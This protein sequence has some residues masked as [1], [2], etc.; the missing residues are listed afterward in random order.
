MTRKATLKN[1]T[2]PGYFDNDFP[3]ILDGSK[4]TTIGA[5][6]KS[7]M[8]TTDNTMHYYILFPGFNTAGGE[9]N[10]DFM[11]LTDLYLPM[12]STAASIEIQPMKQY[13]PNISEW[14]V[15]EQSITFK[16]VSENPTNG[17]WEAV[18]VPTRRYTATGQRFF[19]T[20]A[21]LSIPNERSLFDYNWNQDPTYCT[22]TL[23]D[24]YEHVFQSNLEHTYW[25]WVESPCIEPCPPDENQAPGEDSAVDPEGNEND[26]PEN[27]DEDEPM[28][29]DG[30]LP[31]IPPLFFLPPSRRTPRDDPPEEYEKNKDKI[32][33]LDPTETETEFDEDTG[34]IT[35]VTNNPLPPGIPIPIQ[36]PNDNPQL[37]PATKA[38]TLLELVNNYR[39]AQDPPLPSLYTPYDSNTKERPPAQV[40]Y[41][42]AKEQAVH[43][44]SI[45]QS[46]HETTKFP[47]DYSHYD[48]AHYT[49]WKNKRLGENAGQGLTPADVI[50]QWKNSPDH[51]INMLGDFTHAAVSWQGD[52][53]VLMLGNDNRTTGPSR[54]DNPAV[55]I[56]YH[57]GDLYADE[58]PD[59]IETEPVNE[60]NYVD[61]ISNNARP[62]QEASRINPTKNE[63]EAPLS[64]LGYP[65][66]SNIES[67]TNPY[68][69][70][71][72]TRPQPQTSPS[73]ANGWA[74]VNWDDPNIGKSP[75]YDGH[76]PENWLQDIDT[77]LDQYSPP[78][79]QTLPWYPPLNTAADSSDRY[80][81]PYAQ[82]SQQW[83]EVG[84]AAMEAVNWDDPNIAADP[85]YDGH[86]PS[87]W[88]NPYAQ[89]YI[90][91]EIERQRQNGNDVS[92]PLEK[93]PD[94]EIPGDYTRPKRCGKYATTYKQYVH[95]TSR[96]Q[97]SLAHIDPARQEAARERYHTME[98]M[99]RLYSKYTTPPAWP[100]MPQADPSD[101]DTPEY[102]DLPNPAEV[103]VGQFD[104]GQQNVYDQSHMPLDDPDDQLTYMWWQYARMPGHDTTQEYAYGFGPNTE[105]GAWQNTAPIWTPDT[106]NY[107]QPP[108]NNDDPGWKKHFRPG[109]GIPYGASVDVQQSNMD[110]DLAPTRSIHVSDRTATDYED[111][112]QW[113]W[114]KLVNGEPHMPPDKWF[115]ITTYHDIGAIWWYS[116]QYWKIWGYNNQLAYA[117]VLLNKLNELRPMDL[118]W[119]SN[120]PRILTLGQLPPSIDPEINQYVNENPLPSNFKTIQ[121]YEWFLKILYAKN[122]SDPSPEPYDEI[123]SKYPDFRQRLNVPTRKPDYEETNDVNVFQSYAMEKRYPDFQPITSPPYVNPYAEKLT[124]MELYEGVKRLTPH[125]DIPWWQAGS[126]QNE[127]MIF[128][129]F[130]WAYRDTDYTQWDAT[131]PSEV[132][133]EP[134]DDYDF[135]APDSKFGD[136]DP[137]GLPWEWSGNY[138]NYWRYKQQNTPADGYYDNNQNN[139]HT[140][141]TWNDTVPISNTGP[142][143]TVEPAD[144]YR[145]TQWE[146]LNTLQYLVKGERTPWSWPLPSS[147]YNIDSTDAEIDAIQLANPNLKTTLHPNWQ[148]TDDNSIGV[149]LKAVRDSGIYFNPW[150]Q[151]QQILKDTPD[152]QSPTT[153]LTIPNLPKD[154]YEYKQF[155]DYYYLQHGE[156]PQTDVYHDPYTL[157]NLAFFGRKS[158]QWTYYDIATYQNFLDGGAENNPIFDDYATEGFNT[159][160]DMV[161]WT[162][163]GVY[164][165]LAPPICVTAPTTQTVTYDDHHTTYDPTLQEINTIR[166]NPENYTWDYPTPPAQ[167]PVAYQNA[168]TLAA[169]RHAQD[170]VDRNYWTGA[171]NPHQATN[172]DEPVNPYGE[173][174]YDRTQ[175]FGYGTTQW[176]TEN[177]YWTT[178]GTHTQADVVEAWRQS[179]DP[180]TVG[181]HSGNI[182]DPDIDQIGIGQVE[183]DNNG[184]TTYVYVLVL[185]ASSPNG[186]GT[187]TEALFEA[188]TVPGE[189]CT[190]DPYKLHMTWDRRAH[191]PLSEEPKIV[192]HNRNGSNEPIQIDGQVGSENARLLNDVCIGKQEIEHSFYKYMDTI[193]V[194]IK[195][196]NNQALKIKARFQTKRE[197][198]VPTNDPFAKWQTNN[199]K[200]FSENQQ[201]DY[202]KNHPYHRRDLK[203][204]AYKAGT[205]IPQKR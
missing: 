197:Y 120:F 174:Q 36:A 17:M 69:L 18:R 88:T 78:G 198:T 162:L 179:G 28:P 146:I 203:D 160:Q 77:Y 131:I 167:P 61:R 190:D 204:T 117:V 31:P 105:L 15:I 170:L 10:Q 32:E 90:Y 71:N 107:P 16:P 175:Y 194:R 101:L 181:T 143:A 94:Y 114:P 130:T 168:L 189:D 8:V 83:D 26:P 157:Q 192:P 12:K 149:Y 25:P 169:Q 50:Q 82:S 106:A 80:N 110:I 34:E 151:T 74:D 122:M 81:G 11:Q 85:F 54:Q 136:T 67:T 195:S 43:N 44:K 201:A 33:V 135:D 108:F 29:D 6:Y 185:A 164:S 154:T 145:N 47:G 2:K 70:T 115:Q 95:P 153:L 65:D 13:D 118:T 138:F 79:K 172:G 142:R 156:L 102:S 92:L 3:K 37:Q 41:L 5:S 132:E 45:G 119:P 176:V 193:L 150:D 144:M 86:M 140:I 171:G 126:D 38:N 93:T 57:D 58:E 21:G 123:Q 46:S 128:H 177:I 62:N 53:A 19:Q 7:M 202:L 59:D 124:Y 178:D 104:F 129:L 51:D 173:W 14:R 113:K 183:F 184:T 116:D 137:R 199:T 35:H 99:D 111:Q 63:E 134:Y 23:D 68:N 30:D 165:K 1:I 152:L 22:G 52:F 187:E 121:H 148:W 159:K 87:G 76:L 180:N 191:I 188:E 161:D 24:L 91:D 166:A 155:R 42:A 73:N 96:P 186:G 4:T 205:W 27:P 196:L 60:N 112:K 98:L 40:L 147:D 72:T 84:R 182:M 9:M 133:G 75:Y 141:V 109:E 66:Y 200:F 125:Y 139:N 158:Y 48:R 163:S 97:P 55:P 20:E 64:P 89:S 103:L 100:L 39:A 49:G 127:R 56:I